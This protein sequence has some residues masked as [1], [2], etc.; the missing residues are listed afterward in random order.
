MLI[1]LVTS[2][3][4]LNFML[5]L[6]VLCFNIYDD[7]VARFYYFTISRKEVPRKFWLDPLFPRNPKLKWILKWLPLDR[8]YFKVHFSKGES[9]L[10]I[11][12]H[13]YLLT[14]NLSFLFQ[15]M[16]ALPCILFVLNYPVIRCYWSIILRKEVTWNFG[17]ILGFPVIPSKR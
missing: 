6:Y 13:I 2:I 15:V 8:G 11:P 5:W 10:I 16:F 3:R 4:V 12:C 17:V 1:Y 9:F 14:C 7:H